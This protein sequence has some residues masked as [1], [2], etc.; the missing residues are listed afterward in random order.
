[1]PTKSLEA[2]FPFFKQS[3]NRATKSHGQKLSNWLWMNVIRVLQTKTADA[4]HIREFY[5]CDQPLFWV[6]PD[7]EDNPCWGCLSLACET[8]LLPHC[9]CIKAAGLWVRISLLLCPQAP[10]SLVSRALLFFFFRLCVHNN[11]W[12]QK[13]SE[14]WES[15]GAFIM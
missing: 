10:P 11:T 2:S 7:D 9:R 8:R 4:A 1:M 12:K 3:W 14:K 13:S 6:G 15:L 5:M